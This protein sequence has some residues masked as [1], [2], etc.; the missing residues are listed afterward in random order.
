MAKYALFHEQ[1]NNLSIPFYWLLSSLPPILVMESLQH[2]AMVHLF[3][4]GHSAVESSTINDYKRLIAVIRDVGH[5]R[6]IS[7]LLAPVVLTIELGHGESLISTHAASFSYGQCCS[8]SIRCRIL[9][10]Q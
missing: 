6:L 4:T 9:Q 3:P 10:H 5:N 7:L 8:K 2:R 1:G